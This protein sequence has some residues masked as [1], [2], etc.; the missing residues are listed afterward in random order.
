MFFLCCRPKDLRQMQFMLF[1]CCFH[2]LRATRGARNSNLQALVVQMLSSAIH[3][4]KI[5]PV[6][7]AIGFPNI[8]LLD[9]D[10]SSG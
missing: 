7:S 4:T 3:Q 1:S 6:D 9:S 5:Y 10:S 8:Y 2:L